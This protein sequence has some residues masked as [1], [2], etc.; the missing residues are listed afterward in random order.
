MIELFVWCY[1][2]NIFDTKIESQWIYYSK[3]NI[4]SPEN[5]GNRD[6]IVASHV[7]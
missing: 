1:I 4:K 2:S 5:T 3:G 7:E 6:V